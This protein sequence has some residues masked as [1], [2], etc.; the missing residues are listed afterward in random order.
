MSSSVN[1]IV[2]ILKEG[3]LQSTDVFTNAYN[4]FTDSLDA[5]AQE[6]L[7][8]YIFAT[9]RSLVLSS[10]TL[11][12]FPLTVICTSISLII[13]EVFKKLPLQTAGKQRRRRKTHA[14]SLFWFAVYGAA[15]P[16]SFSLINYLG[17]DRSI[18]TKCRVPA[19]FHASDLKKYLNGHQGHPR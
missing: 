13:A 17:T 6:F 18:T 8:R 11:I 9:R 1:A 15:T 16:L 10:K 14:G 2:P 19:T 3:L 5:R 4:S 7:E 12:D